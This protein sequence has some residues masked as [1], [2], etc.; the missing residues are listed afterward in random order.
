[1]TSSSRLDT[2]FKYR[3]FDRQIIILCVRWYVSDKLSYRDLVEMMAERGIEL[4]TYPKRCSFG[5]VCRP[6]RS[7]N[8]AR[9]A[10]HENERY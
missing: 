9:G 8:A 3:H 1:M 2:L 5:S 4:S 7:P 10:V 6:K